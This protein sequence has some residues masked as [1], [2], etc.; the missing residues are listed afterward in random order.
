M[1][2]NDPTASRGAGAVHTVL[3]DADGVLQWPADGW[4]EKWRPYAGDDLEGFVR[5]MFLAEQPA[6]TGAVTIQECVE[7]V[8]H[9]RGHSGEELSRAV[10][11]VLSAWAMIEV[12]EDAFALVDRVRAAGTR[13][14][15]AS[16]QQRFRRDIMVDLGYAQRFDRTF[17]SCDLG[18][19]KPD[20]GYFEAVLADLGCGPDGVIFVD[21][22]EDNVEAARSVGLTALVHDTHASA[23]DRGLDDLARILREAGVP[24]V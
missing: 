23:D 16:N 15:L 3:L 8:L 14:C 4:L 19:A 9:G 12:F 11:Q 2:S 6:L 10:E 1:T 20:P 5:Q 22:R 21:D 17:F 7:R 24:G 18:V 13:C